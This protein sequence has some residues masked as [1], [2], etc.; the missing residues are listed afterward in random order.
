M[1]TLPKG[2]KYT[3][4]LLLLLGPGLFLILLS[5]GTHKFKT[6]PYYGFKEVATDGDTIYHTVPDFEFTNQNGEAV[7]FADFK[8]KIVVADFIFTT[9]PTICPI[10]TK[11]MTRLQWMLEDPSFNNVKFL[12]HS[13]NPTHDTPE[14]L[15]EYAKANDA[16]L[17]RWTFVTG[18]QQ[19]IFDQGFEGYLLS[20]QE[21][22]GAPGG[23]LHSSNFVLIDKDRHIRGFYDGTSTT[24]V[25]DLV[26]DIKMLMKEETMTEEE[27]VQ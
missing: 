25:D 8:D 16:D 2:F 23:F 10:M 11:Q 5:K 4:L 14:V 20:T 9:C 3:I 12:S 7:S 21:D 27:K 13:V 6:L 26:S 18:D 1:K 19:D 15:M 24:E 22:S 17:S